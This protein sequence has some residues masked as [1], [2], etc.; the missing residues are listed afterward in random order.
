M[1]AFGRLSPARGLLIV[2][3]HNIILVQEPRN[4]CHRKF[5]FLDPVGF[6]VQGVVIGGAEVG[7]FQDGAVEGG[8]GQVTLVEGGGGQITGGKVHF[9]EL[10]VLE[11]GLFD[12]KLE[13]RR[14]VERAGVE[15]EGEADDLAGI[16]RKAQHFAV[17][18]RCLLKSRVHHLRQTQ[19]A[20]RKGTVDE[21]YP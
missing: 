2:L 15:G 6:G 11:G 1:L 13:K 16:K 10:T 4:A 17:P 14:V 12:F 19:V 5:C 20:P 8:P 21:L 3:N 7:F 9:L 18:E